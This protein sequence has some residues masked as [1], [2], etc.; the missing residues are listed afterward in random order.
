MTPGAVRE[1]EGH[2]VVTPAAPFTLYD[3]AHGYIVLTGDRYEYL[4][5]TY[6]AFQPPCVY[7]MGIAYVVHVVALCMYDDVHLERRELLCVGIEGKLGLDESLADYLGP[8][9]KAEFVFW[10]PG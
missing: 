5:V 7:L 4:R 1:R 2:L 6:L 3:A 10:K 8:V 9:D